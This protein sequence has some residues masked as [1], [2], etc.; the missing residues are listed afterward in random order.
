MAI[1]KI[2]HMKDGKTGYHGVHLKRSI[3]YITV[4]DKTQNGRLV[5]AVNC[6]ADRAF[7]QMRET[8]ESFGKNNQRQ[9]YHIVLSFKEGEVDADTVFQITK[10]FVDA[11]VG[12][13]YEAVYAV[14]D[15]TDHI[16]S[17]IVYNSV[18]FVDGMKYHYSKGD[19]ERDIQ[20]ITNRLCKEHGLS[21]IEIDGEK[22]NS[23]MKEWSVNKDGAFV[24]GDMI[25]RDLDACILQASTFDSFLQMLNDKGYEV[26]HGKYLAVKPQGM[27]R[28]KRCKSLGATYSEERIKERILVETI[29]DYIAETNVKPKIVKCYVKRYRRAKMSGLQKKYYAK[30]YRLGKLKKRPYS[31]A[32]KYKDEIKKMQK[33]QR[34][35]LFLARHDIKSMVDLVAVMDSLTDKRKESY[36]EKSVIYK[37]R[38][39]CESLFDIVKEMD[40][41]TCAKNTY[42]NGDTYFEKEYKQWIQLE[43]ALKE[44]G[45]TYEEVNQLKIHYKNQIAEVNKKVTAVNQEL[46]LARAVISDVTPTEVDPFVKDESEIV[47]EKSIEK[48]VEKQPRR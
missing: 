41:L 46:A 23:E 18:S 26:K 9:G 3:D 39:K 42:L 37:A 40:E 22:A 44:E 5:G 10:E 33:L 34:Q 11:Y 21:T 1:S 48:Q 29:K 27:Q 6:L 13:K 16:H 2:M 8:K 47:K 36:S 32:W 12:E 25:K 15:N 35:Y 19:W 43:N 20:P 28:F 30:L 38:A 31:Q 7:E 45:Y 17:H 4:P 14:H 24:W